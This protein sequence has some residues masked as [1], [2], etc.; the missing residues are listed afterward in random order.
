MEN[1]GTTDL[2]KTF[3]AYMG[4]FI[5]EDATVTG[6]HTAGN[7]KQFMTAQFKMPSDDPDD[8]YIGQ[9]K[10][11]TKNFFEDSH[12]LLFKKAKEAMENN[13]PLKIKASR[14]QYPS[15][16]PFYILEADGSIRKNPATGKPVI[17]KMITLFL[18]KDEN[19]VALYESQVRRLERTKAFIDSDIE[20][21]DLDTEEE[22]AAN[23]KGKPAA[24]GKGK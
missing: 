9:S 16:R 24:N 11:Y 14:F 19:P 12:A 13:T 20:D 3:A 1:V 10:L 4:K 15:P 21:V 5:S 6:P 23:P 18:I 8:E 7:D 2:M 22:T 17:V